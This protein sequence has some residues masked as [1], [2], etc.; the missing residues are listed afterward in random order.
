M[1][2]K[3]YEGGLTSSGMLFIPRQ[4]ISVILEPD[5][6]KRRTDGQTDIFSSVKGL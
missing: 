3:K 6:I 1:G 5:E 4:L 2:V